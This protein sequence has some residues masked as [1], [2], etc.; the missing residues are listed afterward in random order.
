MHGVVGHIMVVKRRKKMRSE[1]RCFSVRLREPVPQRSAFD[2]LWQKV[3]KH[4]K[5]GQTSSVL[6]VA[7][8]KK[9]KLDNGRP[10]VTMDF[11]RKWRRTMISERFVGTPDSSSTTSRRPSGGFLCKSRTSRARR[12]SVRG[13][14][15]SE[16]PF[17]F[18]LLLYCRYTAR[19][20]G[21]LI[22]LK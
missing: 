4:Q 19:A 20:A 12:V 7:G 18:E 14:R 15:F 10:G 21:T 22:V 17:V 2:P 1:R 6:R 16:L 11:N 5:E 3:Y 13:G 8:F 9:K